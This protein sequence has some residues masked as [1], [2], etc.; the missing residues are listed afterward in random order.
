MDDKP[1]EIYWNVLNGNRTKA[2][3]KRCGC[4]NCSEALGM[5]KDRDSDLKNG[6]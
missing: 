1:I 3:L 5:L 4:E 2:D 6:K